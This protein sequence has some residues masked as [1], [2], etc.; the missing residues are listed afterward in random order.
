MSV[1]YGTEKKGI[2]QELLGENSGFR[3]EQRQRGRRRIGYV[4]T[5]AV[6]TKALVIHGRR[7]N[8]YPGNGRDPV[9]V[10]VRILEGKYKDEEREI[11]D[12]RLRVS[13]PDERTQQVLQE[14]VGRSS[15]GIVS[16]S[17]RRLLNEVGVD[18][19]LIF[20]LLIYQTVLENSFDSSGVVPT[21]EVNN[22]IETAVASGMDISSGSLDLDAPAGS[23]LSSLDFNSG[24]GFENYD[25]FN[26]GTGSSIL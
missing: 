25:S 21:N 3:V 15:K 22:I 5:D 14:V 13:A 2:V 19:N 11:K 7:R 4:T 26:S 20:W 16:D 9:N 18:D 10:R 17:D 12:N 8:V 6:Y 23:E 1:Y 24:S